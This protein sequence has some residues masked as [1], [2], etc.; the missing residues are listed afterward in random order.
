MRYFSFLLLFLFLILCPH[1][2]VQPSSKKKEPIIEEEKSYRAPSN[3]KKRV[4]VISNFEQGTISPILEFINAQTGLECRLIRQ[5]NIPQDNAAAQGEDYDLFLG[6]CP[7]RI[8]EKI[9]KRNAKALKGLDPSLYR[10]GVLI[11]SRWYSCIAVNRLFSEEIELNPEKLK[12]NLTTVDPQKDRL[13]WL[14]LYTLYDAY[15]KGILEDINNLI[16]LYRESPEELIF[17]IESGSYP[18]VLGIDGY[19]TESIKKGYPIDLVYSSFSRN[20]YPVTTVAGEN[21]AYIPRS[22]ENPEGADYILDF[23]M[24]TLFQ[25]YLAER[26]FRPALSENQKPQNTIPAQC[27]FDRADEFHTQWMEIAFPEIIEE[28]IEKM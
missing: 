20:K 27:N 5:L 7:Q 6:T 13:L 28:M 17:T 18:S 21:I 4:G 14:V 1:L 26:S 15:G 2:W 9:M 16:P 22:S 23:L 3:I 11:W 12:A 24:G 25:R 10:D 19:F 8:P